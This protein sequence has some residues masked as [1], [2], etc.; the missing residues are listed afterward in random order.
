MLVVTVQKDDSQKGEPRKEKRSNRGHMM[1]KYELAVAI[2]RAMDRVRM[3]SRTGQMNRAD[4][5][6]L[7]S[8][9]HRWD[10]ANGLKATINREANKLW[11]K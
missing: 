7:T 9:L 5:A 1:Y 6:A 4:L 8:A 10:N 2:I 3:L 11:R